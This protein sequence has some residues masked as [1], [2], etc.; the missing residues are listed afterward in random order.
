MTNKLVGRTI[1]DVKIASDRQALLFIDDSGNEF[2]ARTDGD[3]C[4]FTWIEHIEMPALGLPFT[5]TGIEELDMP[6]L[7]DM[8]GCEV[9][10]YYGAKITTNKGDIVIDYRNDSNGYYGGNIVWPVTKD[11]YSYFYGG[12]HGQNESSLEW[13]DIE[14]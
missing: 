2:I 13:E 10:T 8:E 11:E 5:I 7:G 1:I 6:D 4:S 12:V 14:E 3:C 9:V